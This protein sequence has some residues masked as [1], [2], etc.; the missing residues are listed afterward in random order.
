MYAATVLHCRLYSVLWRF[1]YIG[2]W[3]GSCYLQMYSCRLNV[4]L[5]MNVVKFL[6]S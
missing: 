3:L 5:F 4:V 6:M 2:S 1:L